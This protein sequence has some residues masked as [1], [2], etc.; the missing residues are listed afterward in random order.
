MII[1][2]IKIQKIDW[3]ILHLYNYIFC[4]NFFVHTKYSTCVEIYIHVLYER[5]DV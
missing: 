4:V 2:R 3:R 1:S 5:R